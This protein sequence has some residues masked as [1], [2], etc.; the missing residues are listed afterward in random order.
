[1][2]KYVDV[3]KICFNVK[4]NVFQMI[5]EKYWLMLNILPEYIE[6]FSFESFVIEKFKNNK[7]FNINYIIQYEKYPEWISNELLDINDIENIISKGVLLNNWIDVVNPNKN[8]LYLQYVIKSKKPIPDQWIDKINIKITI[9]EYDLFYY[10]VINKINIPDK[11]KNLIDVNK[12]YPDN[13]DLIGLYIKTN[14]TDAPMWMKEKY[15]HYS[16]QYICAIY[17]KYLGYIPNYRKNNIPKYRLCKEKKD[18]ICTICQEL[19]ENNIIITQCNHYYHKEC[20]IKW[21]D[22]QGTCPMCMQQL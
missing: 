19:L 20:I 18:I 9:N 15:I 1:M 2:L 8:N 11:L 7:I 17:L 10:Y 12:L 21:D 6:Y 3:A 13:N 16:H 5:P 14:F 22:E 4:I